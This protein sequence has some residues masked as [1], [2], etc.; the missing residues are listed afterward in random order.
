MTLE[1]L[2]HL[3]TSAGIVFAAIQLQLSHQQARTSFEDAL[4]KEYRDLATRIPT[5]VFLGERLTSEEKKETWDDFYHYFD[6][7]NGQ[8]F[9]RQI[10]RVRSQTWRFWSDGM[11]CNFKRDAFSEAWE[12]IQRQAKG[13]FAE[14]RLLVEHDFNIDPRSRRWRKRM[15]DHHGVRT[16]VEDNA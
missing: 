5:K 2:S 4:A 10:G 14:L 3:A 6:L 12:H 15:R 16:A 9:L 13:D 7:C 11:R 1:E 8:A